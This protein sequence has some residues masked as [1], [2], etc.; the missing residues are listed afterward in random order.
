VAGCAAT[1]ILQSLDGTVPAGVNLSGN[2]VM[3]NDVEE[4][5][6]Q[7][8]NAIR[9]TDGV[10][11]EDILRR[12]GPDTTRPN[13]RKNDKKFKG[14]LVY[15][16]LESAAALKVTQTKDG[17]FISFGRAIVE[18]YLFGEDRIASVGEVHAQRVTGWEGN[19]LVVETLDRNGMKL[20]ERFQLIDDGQVLERTIILRSKKGEQESVV[21]LF[22]RMG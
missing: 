15:V 5:D 21:Q 11:E 1:E 17:L 2:W 19:V 4:N 8:R 6:R 10:K 22:D 20:T 9:H 14:G 7:L 18:E 12:P 16:F 13:R 3:R